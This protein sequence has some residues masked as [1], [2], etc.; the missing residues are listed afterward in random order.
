MDDIFKI[1]ESLEESGR[2]IDDATETVKHK[3]KKPEGEFIGAMMAPVAASLIAP[4]ASSLIN[5]ITGK[6]AT[7]TR[8]GQEDGIIPLL[9]LPLTMKVLGKGVRRAGK[10]YSNTDKNFYFHYIL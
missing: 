8:K 5:A 4:L 2:C 3:L 10:G 9:A 1:V 7:R 6:W